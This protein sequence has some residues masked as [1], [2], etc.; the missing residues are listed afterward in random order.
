MASDFSSMRH[1]AAKWKHLIHYIVADLCGLAN[2]SPVVHWRKF[3][4]RVWYSRGDGWLWGTCEPCWKLFCPRQNARKRNPWGD[5]GIDDQFGRDCA[6]YEGCYTHDPLIQLKFLRSSWVVVRPE[7]FPRERRSL[8]TELCLLKRR[9]NAHRFL[10][11][12]TKHGF[13]SWPA[14]NRQN[15]PQENLERESACVTQKSLWSSDLTRNTLE[16]STGPNYVWPD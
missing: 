10:R 9:G 15:G 16:Y 7:M 2:L 11:P 1:I 5:S 8:H 14:H 6:I 12:Q 13:D 4:R 3:Y